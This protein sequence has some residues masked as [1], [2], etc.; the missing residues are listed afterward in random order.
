MIKSDTQWPF[1]TETHKSLDVTSA[2]SIGQSSHKPTLIQ[3]EGHIDLDLL[4][5]GVSRNLQHCLKNTIPAL[6][7]LGLD[8]KSKKKE[9]SILFK[10]LLFWLSVTHT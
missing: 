1:T 9:I 8:L 10:P 4:M 2:Y 5:G 3:G 7:H 6:D